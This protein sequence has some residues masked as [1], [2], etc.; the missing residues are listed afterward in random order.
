MEVAGTG[1]GQLLVLVV[2]EPGWNTVFAAGVGTDLVLVE[3]GYTE[4]A[5][6]WDLEVGPLVTD[7]AT[8]LASVAAGFLFVHKVAEQLVV[9]S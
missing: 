1:V 5:A 4:V 2:S 7:S 8:R 9:G 6:K 3:S